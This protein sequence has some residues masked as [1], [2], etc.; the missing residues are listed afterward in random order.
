MKLFKTKSYV[1]CEANTRRSSY[2]LLELNF[3]VVFTLLF[4]R[5]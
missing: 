5:R 2:N 4:A 1:F 3:P